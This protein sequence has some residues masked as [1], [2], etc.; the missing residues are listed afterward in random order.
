MAKYFELPD[1]GMT[2]LSQVGNKSSSRCCVLLSS[3]I[4]WL[5]KYPKPGALPDYNDGLRLG[6]ALSFTFQKFYMR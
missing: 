5:L 1:F 2:T 4:Q 6:Q 3:L